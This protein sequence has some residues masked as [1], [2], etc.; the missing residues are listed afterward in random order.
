MR[1]IE[2]IHRARPRVFVDDA[3]ADRRIYGIDHAC[4]SI[5]LHVFQTCTAGER[6]GLDDRY[7]I[8][9]T[10]ILELGARRKRRTVNDYDGQRRRVV[11]APIRFGYSDIYIKRRGNSFVSD[12]RI[13]TRNFREA[14]QRLPVSFYDNVVEYAP[15]FNALSRCI[16][17][18]ETFSVFFRIPT[19]KDHGAVCIYGNVQSIFFAVQYF[20]KFFIDRI[21]FAAIVSHLEGHRR[22]I[23]IEHHIA[24]FRKEF[25]R[26]Q[27]AVNR[28]RRRI[29]PPAEII[30]RTLGFGEVCGIADRFI[31]G[32]YAVAQTT[33]ERHFICS[34]TD[35]RPVRPALFIH[36][37]NRKNVFAGA[38][39]GD[40]RTVRAV[41]YEL[42][43]AVVDFDFIHFS[44]HD[45]T[46]RKTPLRIGKRTVK[47]IVTNVD[48]VAPG[49]SLR[50]RSLRSIRADRETVILRRRPPHVLI[51]GG[52]IERRFGRFR[53]KRLVAD[54]DFIFSR[55]FNGRPG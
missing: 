52:K 24:R 20:A 8:G 12:Y 53:H 6:S 50:R 2:Q 31:Y 38:R 19:H 37:T 41:F 43:S 34:D 26:I 47:R 17:I 29:I 15:N 28:A 48:I 14:E 42:R 49:R 11:R 1:D 44:A 13:S 27:R 54:T 35:R 40:G 25:V 30:S 10:D 22:P 39:K 51:D 16:G 5:D 23:R 18:L 21:S 7:T 4:D 36:E 33:V 9:N 55:A 3:S 45:A 32:F 46:P